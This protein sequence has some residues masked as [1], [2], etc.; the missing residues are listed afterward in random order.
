MNFLKVITL[1]FLLSAGGCSILES[2][3]CQIGG[4]EPHEI[5]ECGFGGEND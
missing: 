5:E 1:T 2:T 3:V 4:W